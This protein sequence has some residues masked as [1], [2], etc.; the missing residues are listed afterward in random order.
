[1]SPW[2]IVVETYRVTLRPL[3][4]L[5]ALLAVIMLLPDSGSAAPVGRLHHAAAAVLTAASDTR[6]PSNEA[7]IA[8]PVYTVTRDLDLRRLPPSA[9]GDH[10][11]TGREMLGR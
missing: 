9:F 11:D 2:S 4:R 8:R 3:M 7:L 1:M 10:E 5:A 6:P